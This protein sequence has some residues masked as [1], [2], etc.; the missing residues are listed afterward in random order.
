TPLRLLKSSNVEE[1]WCSIPSMT[2]PIPPIFILESV[3]PARA[4]TLVVRTPS[5][6]IMMRYLRTALLLLAGLSF[7]IP[8]LSKP[9]LAGQHWSP[10]HGRRV[11]VCPDFSSGVDV[12]GLN[13][14]NVVRA[15]YQISRISRAD[16]SAA[17]SVWNLLFSN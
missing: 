17:G 9:L 5:G 10:V 12:P 15:R 6:G 8:L 1:C 4:V 11:H 13:F 14:T 3:G 2:L 16:E 7:M